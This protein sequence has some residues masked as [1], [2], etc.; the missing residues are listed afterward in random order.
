MLSFLHELFLLPFGFF[1]PFYPGMA[2]FSL[3]ISNTSGLLRLADAW[4]HF[5][6]GLVLDWDTGSILF[7]FSFPFYFFFFFW[8]FPG[9]ILRESMFGLAFRVER[10]IGATDCQGN[11]ISFVGLDLR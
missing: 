11:Q 10:D 6:L 2:W 9:G 4:H 1:S 8:V 7:F 5:F 3:L